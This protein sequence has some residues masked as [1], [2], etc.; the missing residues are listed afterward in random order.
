MNLPIRPQIRELED[1]KIVDVWHRGFALPDAIML[2]VGEG[3]LPTPT[4][5]ADEVTATR[6]S[7]ISTPQWRR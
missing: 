6:S 4:F 7:A 5:I 1:S 3:D 2:A